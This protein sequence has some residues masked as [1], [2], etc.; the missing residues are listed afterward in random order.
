MATA[1]WLVCA[2]NILKNDCTEEYTLAG[3]EVEPETF[4]YGLMNPSLY[5][6]ISKCNILLG[7]VC[8]FHR[9]PLTIICIMSI[10]D[11]LESAK[12]MKL[13]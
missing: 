7:Y 1:G 9:N 10:S 3:C 2:F 11:S 5:S 4:Q 6:G 13:I 8:L 12:H